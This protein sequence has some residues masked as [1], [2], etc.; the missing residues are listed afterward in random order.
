MISVV[1]HERIGELRLGM[2]PEQILAAIDMM[3]NQKIPLSNCELETIVYQINDITTIK[4]IDERFFFIVRYKNN[5]AI[6]IGI[7]QQMSNCESVVLYNIDVF[8]TSAE[9]MISELKQRSSYHCDNADEQLA[10]NYYFKDIGIHL[11][12]EDAFH[13][14]LLK[15]EKYLKKYGSLVTEK[16]QYLFFEVIYIF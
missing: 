5:R 3:R 11:W 16:M 8:R 1:P 12:R 6:E 15:N 2:S 10:T 14:K 13:F 9:R 4:Y 7:D